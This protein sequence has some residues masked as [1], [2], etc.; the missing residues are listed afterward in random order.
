M[1]DVLVPIVLASAASGGIMWL[2]DLVDKPSGQKRKP[3]TEWSPCTAQGVRKHLKNAYSIPHVR[4]KRKE[5]NC[6]KQN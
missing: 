4:A 2:L 5:E 3:R 6:G 1:L